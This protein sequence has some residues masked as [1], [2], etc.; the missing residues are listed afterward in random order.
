MTA[1][2]SNKSPVVPQGFDDDIA[3]SISAIENAVLNSH[4]AE[5]RPAIRELGCTIVAQALGLATTGGSKPASRAF[6][7]LRGKHDP[8]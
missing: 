4:S 2:G 3:A 5:P 6:R 8:S 7:W 1:E